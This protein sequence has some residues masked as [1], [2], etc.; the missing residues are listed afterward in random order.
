MINDLLVRE[1]YATVSTY[2]PDVKYQNLFQNSE[3]SAR[4]KNL[5]LWGEA[6]AE[7]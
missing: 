4:E 2:P 1:G 5:G 7:E 3:K 6:C